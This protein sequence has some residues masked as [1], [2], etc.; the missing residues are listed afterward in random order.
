[1][2]GNG[3]AVLLAEAFQMPAG[4]VLHPVE[5]LGVLGVGRMT[6]APAST[7]SVV[8]PPN[9]Q[10]STVPAGSSTTSILLPKWL[11]SCLR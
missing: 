10:R 11:A 5:R 9:P 8:L 6:S 7:V 1:L 4:H 2:P 3:Q